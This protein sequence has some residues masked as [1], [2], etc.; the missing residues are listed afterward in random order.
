MN[1]MG[2]MDKMMGMMDKMMSMGGGAPCPAA[3]HH[4]MR[5]G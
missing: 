2:M 3:P 1:M 5:N 4:G